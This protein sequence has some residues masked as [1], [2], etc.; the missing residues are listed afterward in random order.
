MARKEKG[1]KEYKAG[2]VKS[3]FQEFKTFA[4]KGN[5]IDVAVGMIVGGD[6]R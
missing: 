3:F 4:V 5:M 6:Y 1:A 2:K